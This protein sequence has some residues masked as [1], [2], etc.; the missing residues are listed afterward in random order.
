M[1]VPCPI[2]L[3]EEGFTH[4]CAR[5]DL[6]LFPHKT[7][8]PKC[9]KSTSQNLDHAPKALIF[10]ILILILHYAGSHKDIVQDSTAGVHKEERGGAKGKV[11]SWV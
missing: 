3:L 8:N 11:T 9:S 7:I 1:R 10:K 4:P 6:L 2:L 5:L